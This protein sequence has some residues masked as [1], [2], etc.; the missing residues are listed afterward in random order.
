MKLTKQ[1]NAIRESYK[2]VMIKKDHCSC[3]IPQAKEI[4]KIKKI[5][6][7]PILLGLFIHDYGNTGKPMHKATQ[8]QIIQAN[9][10]SKLAKELFSCLRSQLIIM[11]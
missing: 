6:G 1:V 8:L 7:K 5:T 11:L 10:R 9:T 4:E 3:K 2:S